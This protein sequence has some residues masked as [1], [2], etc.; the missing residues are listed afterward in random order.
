MNIKQVFL[1]FYQILHQE[2]I[3]E[4]GIIDK[5]D[6]PNLNFDPFYL[7]TK[8]LGIPLEI[9]T[10]IHLYATKKLIKFKTI[11]EKSSNDKK[12]QKIDQITLAIMFFNPLNYTAF[13]WRRKL[14]LARKI[15]LKKELKINKI[16][17]TKDPKRSE[18]WI[19]RKW[20]IL[21]FIL[22]NP[23]DLDL[24]QFIL[25]ELNL[26]G[27]C[28]EIYP[29]N[30]HSWTYRNWISKHLSIPNLIH[31]ELNQNMKNWIQ[32][33]VSDYSGM[34]HRQSIIN[35]V[36]LQENSSLETKNAILIDEINLNHNLLIQFPEHESLWHHRKFLFL[37][38]LN[39]NQIQFNQFLIENQSVS[40]NFDKDTIAIYIEKDIFNQKE[41]IHLD[42]V[43]QN[44]IV[45]VD[46][47]QNLINNSQFQNS[48]ADL[49]IS[50]LIWVSQ[51]VVLKMKDLNLIGFDE[52]LKLI[53]KKMEKFPNPKIYWNSFTF[54]K[55]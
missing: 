30:Y 7:E 38:F 26:S 16:C 18:L 46:Y 14:L 4:W 43:I 17:L 48:K 3:N 6:F 39:I 44:E 31:Q 37:K 51:F 33:H 34:N 54:E 12:L 2:K 13:N 42:K 22:N 11:N 50:Y 21:N 53:N 5:Q 41:F 23:N 25:K 55:K 20:M 9:M 52:I 27:Y 28:S 15:N 24:Q 29:R 1:K 36:F 10:S 40:K 49:P 32:S 35:W 19:F 47:C 8:K 45:L